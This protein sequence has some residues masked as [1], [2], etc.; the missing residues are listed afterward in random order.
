MKL[1]PDDWRPQITSAAVI[2]ICMAAAK[3]L[4]P[5]VGIEGFWPFMLSIVVGV[6]L[7]QLVGR[8]LFRPSSG[9]PEQTR[10]SSRAVAVQIAHAEAILSPSL[11]SPDESDAIMAALQRPSS[12]IQGFDLP[13]R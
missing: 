13:N 7:G 8:L 10:Y 4:G 3:Y 1:Y 9:R 11:A 12:P 2:L 6:V 5:M